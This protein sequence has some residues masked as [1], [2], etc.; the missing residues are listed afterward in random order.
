M[1]N[2]TFNNIVLSYAVHD[3]LMSY[4]IYLWLRDLII[5]D[6]VH[7]LGYKMPIEKENVLD[8]DICVTIRR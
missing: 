2:P 6:I 3:S 1:F 4:G 8:N 7:L 5:N